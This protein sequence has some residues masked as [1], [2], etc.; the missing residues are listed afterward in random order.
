[1]GSAIPEGND[2]RRQGTLAPRDRRHYKASVFASRREEATMKILLRN[3]AGGPWLK[4]EPFEFGGPDGETKLESL[5][6][7]S[8]DLLTTEGG[9]PIVFLKKQVT[10]GNNFVDLLGVN[11]DGMIVVVECKLEANREARRMVVGQILEYAG[12]LRGMSYEDFEEMLTGDSGLSLVDF[13]RQYISD[14]AWAEADFRAGVQRGLES[15]EFRLVIAI[16]GINDELKGIVEYLK[17]RG[18][19][20]LEVLELQQ[21]RDEKSGVDVLAPE[22]YGL[23]GRTTGHWPRTWDWES[24]AKDAVQK[25]LHGEQVEAIRELYDKLC[26]TGAE[27]KWDHARDYAS[28]RANWPFSHASVIRVASD[29]RLCPCFGNLGKSETERAFR[30]RLRGLV[31]NKLGLPVPENFQKLYPNYGIGDWKEKIGLLVESLKAILP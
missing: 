14:D 28:F 3:S 18:G 31:V 1:M 30:E 25:G 9:M 8:P 4:L 19:V 23:P 21:F 20:R 6:E 29:G 13:V 10:L 7:K 17:A 12:Q 15:G 2:A 11:A 26:D 22:I 16:N 27:I 5:L 24:F